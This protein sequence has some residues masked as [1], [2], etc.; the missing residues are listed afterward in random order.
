MG[1]ERVSVNDLTTL[2]TD[3]GQV[4]M[5]IGAVLTLT[6]VADPA[7]VVAEL[8]GR[9]AAIP[10]FRQ[11]LIRPG[12]AAGR[13][14]WADDPHFDPSQHVRR[15][16]GEPADLVCSRLPHAR[17]L[18]ALG[19]S[20]RG[21]GEIEVVLVF[22]HVLADGMG[23]LAVLAALA[24]GMPPMTA[25]Q[26]GPVP[27]R[28][29]LVADAL[30]QRWHGLPRTAA[31]ARQAWRGLGELGVFQRRP[32]PAALT[33]LN[34]PTS[35]RRRVRVVRRPLAQIIAAGRPDAT[36]NDVV[37][38]AISQALFDLLARRGEHPGELVISVPIS[39]RSTA[40]TDHLGNEVGAVPI[41][42]RPEPDPAIRLRAIATGT[43]AAKGE[44]RG[45]SALVL[46]WLFRGLA[47][48]HLVQHFLDRQRL[49]HTFETNLRGP[50]QRVRMA[51]CDV[52]G[53][54]PIAVNPG[55]VGVSFDVL[56][57][58][59]EFV[60]AIVADPVLVPELDSLADLVGAQLDA[61]CT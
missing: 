55:N 49:V 3:H 36:V 10:R 42:V 9:L 20:S 54:V 59:G 43:R 39:M 11:R 29:A 7:Q 1:I 41:A 37:L 58:A 40:S 26:S 21:P 27:S 13:P 57:Y 60:I 6:G 2:A 50:S 47:R 46:S 22:H 17:P 14:L 51:G 19:W 8:G 56:S 30:R 24:D 61:L 16:D 34:R 4:P 18:W 23:G 32:E 52:V 45:Q 38:A 35:S 5:N 12:F 44:Q 33:S 48:A 25:E 31:T 28:Q 53:I 15:L